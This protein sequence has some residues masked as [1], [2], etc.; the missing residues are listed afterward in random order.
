MA[1]ISA[2]TKAGLHT[3]LK[4]NSLLFNTSRISKLKILN[5]H[6]RFE[7]YSGG[8]YGTVSHFLKILVQPVELF[9]N[10]DKQSFDL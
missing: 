8:V 3:I 5:N 1:D 4:I 2:M 6:I 10:R 9:Q 7:A